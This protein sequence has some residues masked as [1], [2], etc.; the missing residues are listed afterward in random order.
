MQIIFY[1]P[2]ESSSL[3][4]SAEPH[5]SCSS[6]R[7]IIQLASGV[8]GAEKVLKWHRGGFHLFLFLISRQDMTWMSEWISRCSIWNGLVSSEA[9]N[10]LESCPRGLVQNRDMGQWWPDSWLCDDMFAS[11]GFWKA[12]CLQVKTHKCTF[13]VL[14]VNLRDKLHIFTCDC[15]TLTSNGRRSTIGQHPWPKKCVDMP[16][17]KTEEGENFQN[18]DLDSGFFA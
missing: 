18:R 14:Q 15:K 2:A 9:P 4:T 11:G 1:I 13:C 6:Y 8:W 17:V 5:G 16:N 3:C 10:D 12:Q 7:P